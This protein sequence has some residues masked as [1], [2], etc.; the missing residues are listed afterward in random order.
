MIIP[1]THFCCAQCA[2]R[3][4]DRK[5]GLNVRVSAGHSNGELLGTLGTEL[6]ECAQAIIDSV[7]TGKPYG[8]RV[9]LDPGTLGTLGTQ[10]YKLSGNCFPGGAHA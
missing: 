5:N 9:L 3:A 10:E 1:F 4:Q 6:R 2:H 7:P 8:A